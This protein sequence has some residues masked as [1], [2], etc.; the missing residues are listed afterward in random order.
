MSNPTQ[1]IIAFMNQKGGVGKTTSAVNLAAG[2]AAQ[3]RRVLLIDMDPQG[4]ATLH[5]GHEHVAGTPSVYD[6]MLEPGTALNSAARL[7][8]PNLT[9]L[10]A[11]TDLA[12][13][14]ADLAGAPDRLTRLRSALA[15][16]REQ[17]DFVMIDCPPSLGLL[18]LNALALAREVFIPMQAHFLALQGVGKLLE[19]VALVNQSVNRDL[20]VSGVILC[21]HDGITTHAREV[22]ADLEQFFEQA[23]ASAAGGAGAAAGA[24]SAEATPSSR[25]CRHARVYRP[26][27]RRNIK[28]AECPSFGK[29]IFEYAP[30]CPGAAD[31]RQLAE[32]LVIEQDLLRTGK[33]LA[34]A[35]EQRAMASAAG[36][37][38]G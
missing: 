1:R 15:A 5:L 32:T 9:L 14:E 12:A 4:H 30:W 13:I 33:S 38:Q 19:T 34:D 23:R 26:A 3:G 36:A 7:V 37:T 22:V 10:P 11:E 17:F 28:L 2:V 18:T 27:V 29:H 24:G 35:I 16:S 8:R 6:L 21:A 25:A 31:Y 20:S